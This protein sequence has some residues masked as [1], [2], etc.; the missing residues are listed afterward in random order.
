[1]W[2]VSGSADGAMMLPPSAIFLFPLFGS[3]CNPP[4][5]YSKRED[6]GQGPQIKIPALL[7]LYG[8]CHHIV[9]SIHGSLPF[10]TVLNSC[11]SIGGF[12]HERVE[13]QIGR[14]FAVEWKRLCLR[15]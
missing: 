6:L 5:W 3:G 2:V 12:G 4:T 11:C 14:L 15:V 8:R 9:S 13:I 7:H 10:L 1:M